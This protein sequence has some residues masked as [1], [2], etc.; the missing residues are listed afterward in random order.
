[1]T[2]QTASYTELIERMTP[3]TTLTLRGVSWETYEDLLEAVGE[4]PALRISYNEGVM[5]IMTISFEHE[6]FTE[7]LNQLVVTLR[8]VKRIKIISFGRATMRNQ[9]KL[10]GSEPDACFYVQSAALIGSR[11]RLNLN[12]D[13]A[14]DIVVEV[15]I[16]HDSMS[17]FPIYAALGVGELWRYDGHKLTIHRLENNNYAEVSASA[18]LPLLTAEVLTEF[19][20]LS[21][22]QDQDE[23][24]QAFE[25][26]LRAQP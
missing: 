23:T 16:H 18:A 10:K 21:Q 22:E 11:F 20:S 13:P 17:K 6:Y 1:M 5:Q 14:P 25:L 4:A 12:T 7:V 19:L 9:A 15:D 24:L 2:P 8:F 26:W 3:E